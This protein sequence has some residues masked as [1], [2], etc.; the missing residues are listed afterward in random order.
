MFD[1]FGNA[2]QSKT[3]SVITLQNGDLLVTTPYHTRF[4]TLIK[5]LPAGGR[6][7]EP[8][9]K[10]WLVAAQHGKL[11]REWILSCYGEDVGEIGTTPQQAKPVMRVLDVWYLGRSKANGD[12]PSAS[13]MD[14]AKVWRFVFPEQALREW[15]DG[16][17]VM[18]SAGATLYGILGVN[19]GADADEL[20]NAYRRMVRQWHPDV[21]REPGAHEVFLRIQQAYELLSDPNK[22]ARYDAGLAL[23]AACTQS[24]DTNVIFSAALGYR[25]PLRCGW[26]LAE[27]HEQLGRFVVR[28]ILRWEDITSDQ[29]TLVASWP[30]GAKEPVWQWK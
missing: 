1:L 12:E 29:G 13:G 11:V 28:K 6:R 22:R 21:C 8:T 23:E 26:V 2:V 3:C 30:S 7:Y 24:N 20:K 25:S 10:A 9:A 4:V 18:P 5:G 16:F 19:R 14:A 15:F 27:G 17:T